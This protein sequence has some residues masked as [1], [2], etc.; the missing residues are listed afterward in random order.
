MLRAMAGLRS[1]ADVNVGEQVC[2]GRRRGRL[3]VVDGLV[4]QGRDLSVYGVEVGLRELAGLGHPGGE[5]LQAV[6]LGPRAGD[7][8]GPVGLLVALEVAEIA[9]ELHLDEGRPA[10]AA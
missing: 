9:G 2:L 1:V 10:A 8:V 5:A 7:L 6:E 3:R 4:D